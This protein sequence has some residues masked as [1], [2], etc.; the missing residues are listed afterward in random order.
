MGTMA[1]CPGVYRRGES[2][3]WWFRRRVPQ[4]LL[5]Y[6][7]P[8]KEFAH[9][10]ETTDHSTA[11]QKARLEYVRLDQEF[12]EVRKKLAAQPVFELSKVE[13]QRIAAL[14]RHD[15]L[16]DDES[17]R[18]QGRE[19]GYFERLDVGLDAQRDML[20]QALIQNDASVV[21]GLLEDYQER[22]DFRLDPASPAYKELAYAV[23]Q[24][25]AKTTEELWQRNQGRMVETPQPPAPVR[26]SGKAQPIAA[27]GELTLA[28]LFEK[29]QDEKQR[30][31][32]ADTIT[33]YAS[34]VRH[35]QELHGD[36]PLPL[37]TKTHVREFKDAM[38]KCP[39]INRLPKKFRTKKLPA[40]IKL[41]EKDPSL[42]RLSGRT[43]N[44]KCLAALSAV[45]N[46]GVQNGYLDHNPATGI[47]VAVGKVEEQKR[48]PYSV[49][50]LNLIFRFPVFTEGARPRGGAG[51]AAKWLP[52]L[53]L[54]TGA[55]LQ[56]LGRLQV[57]D[58]RTDRGIT[59]LDLTS[60]G[61]K[62][63]SSKR[64]VPIHK[65]LVR[66]GFL[67]YVEEHRKAKGGP[68]FPALKS[69][70]SSPTEGWTSWW[71][72]YCRGNGITDPRKVFH[73]FRHTVKDGLRDSGVPFDIRS[74]LQGHT[75]PGVGEGYGQGF[76]LHV[77]AEGMDKLHYPGLDLEHLVPAP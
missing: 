62:T 70:R 25:V 34:H 3:S 59:F 21:S 16:A 23:L 69:K 18:A 65:E 33:D 71:G 67:A 41:A 66:L 57:E 13:V 11:C 56:E 6:Y 35:F 72:R 68:L 1:K 27:D 49:E 63:T 76:A 17:A 26:I 29:W 60:A 44:E 47:K 4:D 14:I 12:S 73:S 19:P 9:S 37:I 52:I 20:N 40:L 31:L 38:L 10:L 55:R 51:E 77:L 39:A 7:A 22:L 45:L 64:R 48:L 53:A 24:A 8:K 5:A 28:G 15:M 74:I 2:S 58:V 75:V 50:D 46:W 43:I 36:L 61:T 32:P 42:P 30:T 54:F